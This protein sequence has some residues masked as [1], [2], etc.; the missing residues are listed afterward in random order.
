LPIV[1]GEVDYSQIKETKI[2]NKEQIDSLASIFYNV[3]YSGEIMY[4]E[5][6]GCYN[7]RNAVLFL[8]SNNHLVE[9]IELCFECYEQRFSS[10]RI[11]IGD[12]CDQ[13]SNMIKEF[14]FRMGIRVGTAKRTD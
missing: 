6:T 14:F 5:G 2:L 13:K 1:K 10:D 8:D 3:T 12:L 7:P 4:L 9:F 11:N